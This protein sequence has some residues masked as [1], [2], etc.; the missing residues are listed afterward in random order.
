MPATTLTAILV[1]L[2][3]GTGVLLLCIL[4]FQYAL[5]TQN[6][7]IAPRCTARPPETISNRWAEQNAPT[8]AQH[9]CGGNWIKW[10][11]GLS[12]ATLLHGVPGTGT[13]KGGLEGSMLY[14]TLDCIVLIRFH[15][16]G[17]K[18]AA[19]ATVLCLFVLMPLYI[20]TPQPKHLVPGMLEVPSF[21]HA[22]AI[23]E[24]NTS[25]SSSSLNNLIECTRDYTNHTLSCNNSTWSLEKE[26]YRLQQEQQQNYYRRTTMGNVPNLY[27]FRHEQ[28]QHRFHQEQISQTTVVNATDLSDTVPDDAIVFRLRA[29]VLV[30]WLVTLYSYY[31]LTEEWTQMVSLRRIWY[32]EQRKWV[33]DASV[34][35]LPTPK[36]SKLTPSKSKTFGVVDGDSTGVPRRSLDR[37]MS[38]SQV[39]MSE[40]EWY[41]GFANSL[42]NDDS[43]DEDEELR[44]VDNDHL[45]LKDREAWIPHPEQP[46]TPP[47][48]EPYSVLIGPLPKV[49]RFAPKDGNSSPIQL[50]GEEK[51]LPNSDLPYPQ[52]LLLNSIVHQ[53]EGQLP[54]EPGYSSPICAITVVPTA[55]EVGPVWMV[56]YDTLKKLRRLL[57]IRKQ[58]KNLGYF[59]DGDVVDS[60]V[61]DSQGSATIAEAS[62]NSEDMIS[63]NLYMKEVFGTYLLDDD[64]IEQAQTKLGP[65]QLGVYSR[66]LAQ[67]AAPCCPYGC[68]EGQVRGAKLTRLKQLYEEQMLILADAKEELQRIQEDFMFQPTLFSGSEDD[69]DT[70]FQ[71]ED[72]ADG[73]GLSL[74]R[75]SNDNY[76][77]DGSRG[78]WGSG[79]GVIARKRSF[80]ARCLS[81]GRRLEGDDDDEDNGTVEM[82]AAGAASNRTISPTSTR[83][84][85]TKKGFRWLVNMVNRIPFQQMYH[86][87][88]YHAMELLRKY[89]SPASWKGLFLRCWKNWDHEDP[90]VIVTFTSRRAA[91]AARQSLSS[92]GVELNDIPVA[93]LADAGALRLL[94]FRFFCRP[95]TVTV[96]AFQKGFRW[97][98]ILGF[99]VLM[100]IFYTIPLT[101][102]A[103]R[104]DPDTIAYLFPKHDKIKSTTGVSLPDLLSGLTTSIIWSLFFMLCPQVFK[105]IAYSGSNAT[106]LAQ[107]ER[108]AHQYFWWFMLFTAFAGPMLAYWVLG[109]IYYKDDSLQGG[110]RKML[111]AI[112]GTT[113]TTIAATWINWIIYRFTIILPINFLLQFNTFMF[114]CLGCNC[115]SRLTI[116]GGPGGPTP[117]RLFVDSGVVLMCCVALSPASPL[118][119]PASLVYFVL[120][121]PL[122][123][124]NC[125][126]VYRQRYDDG[127][128][129][130]IFV[131]DMIVSLLIVGQLLLSL[132]MVLKTAYGCSFVSALAIPTTLSFQW[133]VKKR[134][135]PS[136]MNTALLRTNLLDGKETLDDMTIER[137]EEHRRY[138][139]DAHR[140]AY[141]PACL[142][143]TECEEA[144]TAAPSVVIK[145]RIID[146]RGSEDSHALRE[147][148]SAVSPIP[149]AKDRLVARRRSSGDGVSQRRERKKA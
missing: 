79:N 16:L 143:G 115:C 133:N 70:D 78:S 110:L 44:N 91:A 93:P 9:R 38:M 92:S 105:L 84:Q 43:F 98:M 111:L 6:P 40:S 127:G 15:R 30:V 103:N 53:L 54:K 51:F 90:Y 7:K 33:R 24:G 121:E 58:M 119:A 59:V 138:L 96:N 83:R 146:S 68:F 65:E 49:T 17:R 14:V 10:V 94:P 8:H 28:S 73:E 95:V 20:T 22:S 64:W 61:G 66:E 29:A 129:R 136:F 55:K 32:L 42:D 86:Q 139:V 123:R 5:L 2:L 116:G 108:C 130:W 12:E 149:I 122:L 67:A 102:A 62:E 19:L 71:D 3:G 124:R 52:Q 142:C 36:P 80:A 39:P 99:L 23:Q 4:A 131:F 100:C 114:A 50:K 104:L 117:Y 134:Y 145:D 37:R 82:V 89:K 18:L 106:S 132:Q 48:I 74:L 69:D 81:R 126:F 88:T 76:M 46:D 63:T 34:A 125:I 31:L 109:A 148:A 107:A 21:S 101:R 45:H 112:A 147:I 57:F 137:R 72:I 27:Y 128:M 144:L 75:P 135:K 56:W 141:I 1:T 26:Q 41:R 97:S 77:S 140:A 11:M 85:R 113:P 47:N 60:E 118:V 13:R 25:S 35:A 120:L 87:F